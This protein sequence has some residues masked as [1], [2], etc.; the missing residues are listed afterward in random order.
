M[1]LKVKTAF[2]K[3][4]FSCGSFLRLTY[5]APLGLGGGTQG[6][7]CIRLD[8]ASLLVTHGL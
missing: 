2:F 7:L 8:L 5:L 1:C 3:V 4:F 6:L